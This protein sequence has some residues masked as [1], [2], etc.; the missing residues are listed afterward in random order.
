MWI[1]KF[2]IEKNSNVLPVLTFFVFISEAVVAVR[3]F[4]VTNNDQFGYKI[5]LS[6][7]N[8]WTLASAENLQRNTCAKV[9][10]EIMQKESK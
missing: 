9:R 6:I 3:C 8:I 10:S 4:G 2:G 7:V 1:Q 5:D